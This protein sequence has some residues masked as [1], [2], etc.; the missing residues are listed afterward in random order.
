MNFPILSVKDI[1]EV[2]LMTADTGVSFAL[3]FSSKKEQEFDNINPYNVF[4]G[5]W[6]GWGPASWF[7]F[8]WS[9][10]NV[11]EIETNIIRENLAPGYT[12]NELIL[13]C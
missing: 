11:F 1:Y 12:N 4:D 3:T 13:L 8:P 9:G 6:G 5:K 7:V 10:S 2:Q